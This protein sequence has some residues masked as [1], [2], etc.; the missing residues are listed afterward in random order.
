MD[1]DRTVGEADEEEEEEEEVDWEPEP[2][3]D[4]VAG[5]CTW[6]PRCCC[7]WRPACS[8]QVEPIGDSTPSETSTDVRGGGGRPAIVSKPRRQQWLQ[9]SPIFVFI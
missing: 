4:G 2:D 9:P 3:V 7:S 6:R 8:P 1:S 5:T